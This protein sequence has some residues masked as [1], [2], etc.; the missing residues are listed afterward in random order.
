MDPAARIIIDQTE[1]EITGSLMRVMGGEVSTGHHRT[2]GHS[3]RRRPG[4][5]ALE[6]VCH[7]HR[8][9]RTSTIAVASQ[10]TGTATLRPVAS[11]RT[12]LRKDTATTRGAIKTM[13][14]TTGVT[15]VIGKS[16]EEAAT[17]D[18][19]FKGW[20]PLVCGGGHAGL[21]YE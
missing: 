21:H 1:V 6:W 17:A 3:T 16:G 7:R 10:T 8:H 11:T 20:V 19:C 9:R 15:V 18:S 13:G 5:P 14:G 2:R 4:I 12:N